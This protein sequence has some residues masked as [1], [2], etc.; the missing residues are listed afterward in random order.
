MIFNLSWGDK[1]VNLRMS[2]VHPNRMW[3]LSLLF[4]AIGAMPVMAA[5]ETGFALLLESSPADGGSV[6][7]GNGVHRMQIDEAVTLTAVPQAGFRFL[8]WVGD[9]MQQGNTETTIHMDGPKLV[10]AVFVR[11]EFDTKLP[12][13]E[14][15][16][17][18]SDGGLQA[19][20][21]PLTG[22]GNVTPA[23]PPR[24]SPSTPT[25]PKSDDFPVPEDKPV[26]EPTTILLLTAGAM[27]LGRMRGKLQS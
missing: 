25:P 27:V 2:H 14:I 7:P 24:K 15:V 9:V 20:P 11:E 18:T 6:T 3:F 10:V 13:A 5:D 1:K 21:P 12:V 8:Y 4:A 16:S 19:S 22:A 17:G 26:P 23:A